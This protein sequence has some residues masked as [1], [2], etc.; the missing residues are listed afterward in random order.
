MDEVMMSARAFVKAWQESSSI[1]EVASKVRRKKSAVRVR[2]YRY[3]QRGV[4]LKE[5]PPPELISPEEFWG[6]LTTYAKEL[7]AGDAEGAGTDL[8][9]N[10]PLKG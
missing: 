6:E 3:R 1:A 8:E 2:A 9:P 7:V 10:Q 4:P 5:F